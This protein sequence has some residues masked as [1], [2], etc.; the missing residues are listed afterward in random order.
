MLLSSS[1]NILA[2]GKAFIF[3]FQGPYSIDLS[4]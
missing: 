1:T 4:D 2:A 3:L